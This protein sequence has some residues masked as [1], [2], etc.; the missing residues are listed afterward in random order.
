MADTD[1]S[2]TLSDTVDTVLQNIVKELDYDMWKDLF[3]APEE[4]EE[5]ARK[6]ERLRAILA[7]HIQQ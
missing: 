1:T 4:P 3:V 5:S 2:P 7:P 6:I